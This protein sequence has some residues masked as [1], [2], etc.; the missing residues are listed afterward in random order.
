M[1]YIT[2]ERTENTTMSEANQQILQ[3]LP[4]THFDFLDYNEHEESHVLTFTNYMPYAEEEREK[5][6]YKYRFED[7]NV[8]YVDSNVIRFTAHR[9]SYKRIGPDYP[10]YEWENPKEFKD[11]LDQSV[12]KDW[13]CRKKYY[14]FG[15]WLLRIKIPSD[16]NRY[17][18]PDALHLYPECMPC[19][20]AKS[21]EVDRV[22]KYKEIRIR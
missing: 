4:R 13:I 6:C 1:N 2:E 3:F 11:L 9:L 7:V 19:V 15:S 10:I 20:L 21:A 22:V 5:D 18:D 8:Y 14:S 17:Y 16:R 12:T